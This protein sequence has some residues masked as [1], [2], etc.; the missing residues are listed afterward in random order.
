MLPLNAGQGLRA[1]GPSSP[2]PEATTGER[3]APWAGPLPRTTEVPTD[4]DPRTA[5]SRSKSPESPRTEPDLHLAAFGPFGLARDISAEYRGSGE[6]TPVNAPD[7]PEWP[8][9]QHATGP[10]L[11]K[12]GP[13]AAHVRSSQRR[14]PR[15]GRPGATLETRP[16][17]LKFMAR[18]APGTGELPAPPWWGPQESMGPTRKGWQRREP[19]LPG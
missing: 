11:A 4:R 19:S 1:A 3:D 7:S 6:G 14:Q 8:I 15:L 12:A 9:P 13:P 17:N 10:G 2:T 18:H 16:P 5:M